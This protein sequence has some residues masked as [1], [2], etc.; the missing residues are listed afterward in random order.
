M[1]HLLA[2]SVLLTFVHAA[3]QPLR[4]DTLREVTVTAIKESP[5]LGLQPMSATTVGEKTVERFQINGLQS[6]SEIAPN[7]YMPSYGSRI[8]SSIYVRGLGTRMDQPAVGLTVD[9][10]PVLN[11][12]D[13]DIDLFDVERIEV[14]RGPQAS[15]FGRNSMGGQINVYTLSPLRYQGLRLMEEWSSFNTFRTAIGIYHKFAPNFGLG[16]DLN[17]YGTYGENQNIY[18]RQHF[19]QQK[20]NADQAEQ[21]GARIKT[22][23]EARPNV[24]VDNVLAFSYNRQGGYPYVNLRTD[25]INYNDTCYYNR[26]SVSD[27]LTVQWRTKDFTLSS[28]TGL[29]FMDDK[30]ALDQ[31]FTPLNFFTLNQNQREYSLT[32]DVVVRGGKGRYH[33]TAGAFGFVRHTSMDAPVC[34]KEDGI[35]NLILANMP[36]AQWESTHF[37]LNSK[38]TL[39]VW[40]LAAYHESKVDL[41]RWTLAAALR[42]DYEHTAMSYS[43]DVQTAMIFRGMRMP[44]DIHDTDRFATHYLQVLPRLTASYRLPMC[45]PSTLYAAIAKGYKA[46]GYNTQI[47]SDILQNKMMPGRLPADYDVNNVTSYRPEKAWNY[48]LGGHFTC[49]QGRVHTNIAAFF[50]LVTDQQLTVFPDGMTTGRMTTNAGRTRSAG[51]EASITAK[52]STRWDISASYGFTDARFLQYADHDAQGIPV[53]YRGKTVPY[54]PRHTLFGAVTYRQPLP[55]WW[56]G[57]IEITADCR[58]VGPIYWNEANTLR[59]NLY[60]LPDANVRLQ[61]SHVSF[62]F[63]AKNILNHR[64]DA[65]YFKSVG[66]EFVQRGQGRSLG[67][68]L[69]YIM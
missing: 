30:L 12:N 55:M 27:G 16:V 38:F 37:Y 19:P 2:L 56:F 9:N 5:T 61:F 48:E 64:Y 24:S 62:D 69:R 21:Y 6:L 42:L 68:T 1:K 28:I 36:G 4:N 46:G 52:P 33:W 63:W 47:F 26:T 41:G 20:R 23:W 59:Q 58:A 31:D 65:F 34:M 11:K 39:P 15:L 22:A 54:A 57:A 40:G 67:V 32:Q 8:T 10:V 45:E 29:R 13:Y 66:N 43:Q 60:A 17:A 44:I 35:D 49:A 53:D 51:I 25:E 50:M 3:A 14:I 18:V 7:F